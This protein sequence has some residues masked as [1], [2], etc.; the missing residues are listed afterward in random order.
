VAFEEPAPALLCRR[1]LA[2]PAKRR[3]RRPIE[4]RLCAGISR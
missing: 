4:F 3:E 1:I 2:M